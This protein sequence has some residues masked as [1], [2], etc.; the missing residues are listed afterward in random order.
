MK[1]PQT[2]SDAYLAQ[3]VKMS[4]QEIIQ[5]LDDFRKI[6]GNKNL[7]TNSQKTGKTRSKLISMKVP[8]DLLSAFKTKAKLT[9]IPYQTQIKRLMR[10][11]L[12]QN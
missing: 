5:F 4:P 2:F 1:A 10:D 8:E 6:H 12:Q 9:D 7:P 11:W 3:C